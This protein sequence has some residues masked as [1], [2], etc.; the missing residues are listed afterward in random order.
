MKQKDA[1]IDLRDEQVLREMFGRFYARACIFAGRFMRD[2]MLAADLVQEA[3]LYMWQN[4]LVLTDELAFKAYLYNCVRNKCLNYLR[5]HRVELQ[6]V[7]LEEGIA[8]EMQVDHWIIE[9]E[10]RA[11]ILE[12]IERLPDVRREIMMM[13]LEGNS[14]EEISKEL[15][16]NINTL[17]TYKKQIYK[18]LRI[19]LKDLDVCIWWICLLLPVLCA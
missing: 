15:H 12:E 10:L 13:R 6:M 18:E 3:F 8:D 5:D 16:L 4:E 19:R 14:F 2:G 1:I 11:R 9:N 17:K 7:E